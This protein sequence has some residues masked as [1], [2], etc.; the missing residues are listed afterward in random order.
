METDEDDKKTEN[1]TDFVDKVL[2]DIAA[3]IADKFCK[4]DK[5]EE[6]ISVEDFLARMR[7][8]CHTLSYEENL[9]YKDLEIKLIP[10]MLTYANKLIPGRVY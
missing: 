6:K 5:L 2:R 8:V 3:F 9:C 1:S 7:L 4:S 10:S